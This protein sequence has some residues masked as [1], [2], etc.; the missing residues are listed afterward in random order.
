MSLLLLVACGGTPEA[1]A[2][3]DVGPVGELAVTV[4]HGSA[5]PLRANVP[6]ST[7]VTFVRGAMQVMVTG[8]T[9][10]C[11]GAP[12]WTALAAPGKVDLKGVVGIGAE[13]PC[14]HSQLLEV[15]VPPS[16]RRVTVFG[17]DG[18]LWGAEDV[19]ETTR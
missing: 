1:S 19:D 17:P 9:A 13:G 12:V 8:I 16:K 18:A 7:S 11:D 4:R 15:P 2:P 14:A 6:R 3:V 10:P 5:L